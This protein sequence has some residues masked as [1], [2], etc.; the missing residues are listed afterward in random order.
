MVI[1]FNLYLESLNISDQLIDRYVKPHKNRIGVY[2]F[3]FKGQYQ[4]VVVQ[5]IMILKKMKI[6]CI[7][8]TKD[9]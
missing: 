5:N 8:V 2:T 9:S 1:L 7:R 4:S 3:Q 6:T